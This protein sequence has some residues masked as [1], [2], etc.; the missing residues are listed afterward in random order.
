MKLFG[1]PEARHYCLRFQATAAPAAHSSVKAW[2]QKT[3]PGTLKE[4][5]VA[6]DTYRACALRDVER[7]LFQSVSL[8]RRSFDLMTASAAGWAHVTLYYGTFFSAR[9]LIGL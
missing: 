9:A 1:I 8:Y 7:S 6:F 2:L 4:G 5:T 3:K